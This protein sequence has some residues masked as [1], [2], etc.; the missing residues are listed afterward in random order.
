MYYSLKAEDG[1]KLSQIYPLF[2]SFEERRGKCF[3]DTPQ[4]RGEGLLINKNLLFS[5]GSGDIWVVD[6]VVFDNS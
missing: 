3:L 4:L 2:P 1:L 6:Y 5:S